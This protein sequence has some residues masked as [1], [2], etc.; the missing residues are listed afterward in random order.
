M[1]WG[2]N[3]TSL[4]SAKNEIIGKIKTEYLLNMKILINVPYLVVKVGIA[5]YFGNCYLKHSA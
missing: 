1:D 5:N 3:I 4:N 2:R